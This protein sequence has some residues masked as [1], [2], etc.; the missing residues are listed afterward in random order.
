MIA[1]FWIAALTTTLVVLCVAVHYEF[2]NHL[3]GFAGSHGLPRRMGVVIGVLLAL[4]AHVLEIWIFAVGYYIAL[5]FPELGSFAGQS[6]VT[7]LADCVYFS[8]A[9]YTTLGFGDIIPLGWLRF[10]VGVEA[11]LGLVQLA[12]TASFL[13]VQMQRNWRDRDSD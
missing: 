2:L 3:A 8:F 7:T 13:Y 12:W 9:V 10:T 6:P 11:M 4:V 1:M 5:Q